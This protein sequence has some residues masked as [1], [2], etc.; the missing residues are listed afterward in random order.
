LNLNNQDQQLLA[1]RDCFAQLGQAIVGS[2]LEQVERA[3]AELYALMESATM[4]DADAIRAQRPLVEEVSNLAQDVET[5]LGSRLNAFD[6]AIDAWHKAEGVT[7][8]P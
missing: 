7:H 8:E 1:L 4:L 5:L 2:D 3:T 6:L